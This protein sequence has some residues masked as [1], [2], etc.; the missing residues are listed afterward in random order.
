MNKDESIDL[1]CP[2]GEFR[3]NSTECMAWREIEI[4]KWDCVLLINKRE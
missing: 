1:W 3:C 2:Y 4:N